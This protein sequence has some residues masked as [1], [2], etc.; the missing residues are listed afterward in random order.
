MDDVSGFACF[1]LFS[2]LCLVYAE[3]CCACFAIRCAVVL[4]LHTG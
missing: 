3:R 1:R 2:L 4:L